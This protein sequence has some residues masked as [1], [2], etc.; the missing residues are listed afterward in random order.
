MASF[1]TPKQSRDDGAEEPITGIVTNIGENDVIMGRG[2]GPNEN[3]GN[4]RFRAE[5][6][7]VY[8]SYTAV[9]SRS[10]KNMIARKS[11]EVVKARKGR[12]LR[13]LKKHEVDSEMPKKCW[14]HGNGDFYRIVDDEDILIQ[15]AKQNFRFQ[16]AKQCEDYTETTNHINGNGTTKN[17][18]DI[19]NPTR[20]KGNPKHHNDSTRT[21]MVDCP[22]AIVSMTGSVPLEDPT[23]A[24]LP[25]SHYSTPQMRAILG[26]PYRFDLSLHETIG[27]L[28][29]ALSQQET[30]FSSLALARMGWQPSLHPPQLSI[31]PAAALALDPAAGAG[32]SVGLLGAISAAT[33]LSQ[34]PSFS[35]L[36]LASMMLQP[37]L[38]L[39]PTGGN[40]LLGAILASQLQ[41][42]QMSVLPTTENTTVR[43]DDLLRM[44]AMN[45]RH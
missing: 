11:I 41:R 5:V 29:A 7:Q 2:T 27:S 3:A 31:L 36:A 40:S 20:M 25:A 10:E 28:Q 21:R 34:E 9:G 30:S 26:G 12:F 4:V 8:P 44:L 18:L 43:E 14:K 33:T 19:N 16:K 35:S 1:T 23:Q 45:M 37:N 38:A 39:S 13:K 22:A 17:A 42:Q 15:K 24:F 32:R 6:R